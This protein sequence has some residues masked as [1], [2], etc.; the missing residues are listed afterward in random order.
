MMKCRNPRCTG[1]LRATGSVTSDDGARNYRRR[2]CDECGLIVYTMEAFEPAAH[3]WY[4]ELRW[5]KRRKRNGD[6][7]K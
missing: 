2:K 4:S 5:G 7:G 1:L 6:E 3:Y